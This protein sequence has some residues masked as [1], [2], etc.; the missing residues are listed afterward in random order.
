MQSTSSNERLED[1]EI[2]PGI[3][4]VS[5]TQD[6]GR[7]GTPYPQVLVFHGSGTTHLAIIREEMANALCPKAWLRLC[8]P[9]QC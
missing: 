5:T 3:I 4:R 6:P 9:N 7:S 8:L 2:E 1:S